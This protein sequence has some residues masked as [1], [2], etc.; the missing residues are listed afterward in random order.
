MDLI[1]NLYKCLQGCCSRKRSRSPYKSE[2]LISLQRKSR[3]ASTFSRLHTSNSKSPV[4]FSDSHPPLTAKELYNQLVHDPTSLSSIKSVVS[5]LS[6]VHQQADTYLNSHLKKKYT[7]A[8]HEISRGP[9]IRN[10]SCSNLQLFL[11][12]HEVTEI[13]E[14]EIL[15][16]WGSLASHNDED[17]FSQVGDYKITYKDARGIAPGN[18]IKDKIIN[19][20]LKL[21]K[22]DPHIVIVNADF[23]RT[24]ETMQKTQWDLVK[25]KRILR[26][27]GLDKLTSKP[28]VILLVNLNQMQWVVACLNN[29]AKVIEFYDSMDGS[30]MEKVCGLLEI[31]LEKLDIEAYDWECM[32]SPK[33]NNGYDCGIF[34]LKTIQCLAKNASFQF[35]DADMEYYRKIMLAEIKEGKL[36]VDY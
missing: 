36:F 31:L 19:P 33:Q 2:N 11:E 9:R 28:Y 10:Q 32:A 1:P 5:L 12:E 3:F 30:S 23:Y 20:Y 29:S 25:L 26:R 34:A 27:A 21:C 17:I 8:K 6:D 13:T 22:T 16:I 35:T 4:I 14:Q 24:L 15:T 18:W 7:I